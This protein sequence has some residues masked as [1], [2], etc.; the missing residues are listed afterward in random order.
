[1][2]NTRESIQYTILL[3]LNDSTT[4]ERTYLL[5]GERRGSQAQF[6]CLAEFAK[7]DKISPHLNKDSLKFAI[8]TDGLNQFIDTP[9]KFLWLCGINPSW[10]PNK[11]EGLTFTT[12]EEAHAISNRLHRELAHRKVIIGDG[13]STTFAP[14]TPT[15]VVNRTYP[16][17]PIPVQLDGLPGEFID[18][19]TTRGPERSK[20]LMDTMAQ[21]YDEARDRLE[22][23][24]APATTKVSPQDASGLGGSVPSEGGE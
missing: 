5:P 6:D 18:V 3:F 22:S 8:R 16:E 20:F 4:V 15:H 24:N 14:V 11:N 17:N 2:S 23:G 21:G 7:D 13:K 9:D 1:M 19:L 12:M 10:L